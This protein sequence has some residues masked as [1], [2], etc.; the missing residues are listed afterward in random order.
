MTQ[1]LLQPPT[2]DD[3]PLQSHL[4]PLA[5]SVDWNEETEVQKVVNVWSTQAVEKQTRYFPYIMNGTAALT[6]RHHDVHGPPL[7]RL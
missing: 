7:A 6:S 2:A 5:T 3:D 4:M 1:N